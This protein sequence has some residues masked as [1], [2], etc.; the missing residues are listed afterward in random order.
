MDFVK[1]NEETRRESA[2]AP[3]R[4]WQHIQEM[5]A[6]TEANLPEHLR[7]NT[8]QAAKRAEAKLLAHFSK[9]K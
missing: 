8:P 3:A 4:R 1:Q 6:W 2:Y 9:R 5:I 7:R